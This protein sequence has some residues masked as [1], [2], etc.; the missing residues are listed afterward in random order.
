MH[1]LNSSKWIG[2]LEA[3]RSTAHRSESGPLMVTLGSEHPHS[4]VSVPPAENPSGLS[5][6]LRSI[7]TSPRRGRH[8]VGGGY[9]PYRSNHRVTRQV[10]P[11]R[12][13]PTW[14]R[15]GGVPRHLIGSSVLLSRAPSTD[16]EPDP[17]RNTPAP[18]GNGIA[19]ETVTQPPAVKSPSAIREAGYLSSHP[20]RI[21]GGSAVD[22]P[23]V[24]R[25][26]NRSR[27]VPPAHPSDG[28]SLV[29]ILGF[30]EK[31][32][33]FSDYR[34]DGISSS[35]SE[36]PDVHWQDLPSLR[37]VTAELDRPGNTG[38][39]VRLLWEATS[40]V[41]AHGGVSPSEFAPVEFE[42]R[43]KRRIRW[44]MV[45][46]I[47]VLLGLV[48]TTVKVV[49]DLPVRQARD[50]EGHFAESAR[51]LNGALVPL[52]QTLAEGGLLSDSGLA[53]L[54]ER[55]YTVDEVARDAATLASQELPRTSILAS[56][57]TRE[58][59]VIIRDLLEGA[60]THSLEVTRRIGYAMA[61]HLALSGVLDLPLLATE[62]SRTDADLVA[63][64]LGLAIANAKVTLQE[65][66]EDA[67]FRPYLEEASEV[68]SRLEVSQADY[69]AALRTGN[70]TEAARAG[71]SI[72]SSFEDLRSGLVVPLD[73][74]Q[75]WA[76]SEIRAIDEEIRRIESLIAV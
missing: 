20:P 10:S 55:I 60:A 1:D 12:L 28:S 52:K 24:M 62:A 64:E 74:L 67:I 26:L 36:P 22:A 53:T 13:L 21:P 33:S 41:E 63:E 56:D 16:I 42:F 32:A 31:Q 34:P 69:V 51:L 45:L 17:A 35:A 75:D 14:R 61:Y 27:L 76:R 5:A 65:L 19:R 4:L 66:P 40:G 47:A 54:T 59:L 73:H 43:S 30:G 68:L 58:G 49:A 9:G 71:E 3:G 29:S 25:E 18:A 23:A 38:D 50:R 57:E 11:A 37:A 8:R 39:A 6:F 72:S 46:S 48:A 70:A 44:S 15:R 7:A 2:A